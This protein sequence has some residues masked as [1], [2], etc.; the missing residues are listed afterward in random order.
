MLPGRFSGLG[1]PAPVASADQQYNNYLK[2]T[3]ALAEKKITQDQWND[4]D[5]Q[6]KLKILKAKYQKKDLLLKKIA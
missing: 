3:S 2:V 5:G 6:K 4:V 1:I